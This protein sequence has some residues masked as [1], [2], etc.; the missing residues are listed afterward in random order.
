[1]PRPAAMATIWRAQGLPV[2]GRGRG[3]GVSAEVATANDC[4]LWREAVGVREKMCDEECP[5]E[6]RVDWG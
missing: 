2:M 3:A 5:D 1:M 4:T 6:D